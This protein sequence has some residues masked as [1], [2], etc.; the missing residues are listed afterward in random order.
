[1]PVTPVVALVGLLLLSL[2]AKGKN[3]LIST[4]YKNKNF[5]ILGP[6]PSFIAKHL[7]NFTRLPQFLGKPRQ[8][9]LFPQN[10]IQE[11]TRSRLQITKSFKMVRGDNLKTA[12][13]MKTDLETY[14]IPNEVPT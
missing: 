10:R 13:P 12:L 5:F 3:T 6:Q 8:I 7:I 9:L 11:M 1:V 4:K 14:S 2:Q